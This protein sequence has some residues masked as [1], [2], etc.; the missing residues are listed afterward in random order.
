MLTLRIETDNRW[1]ALALTRK[2]ARYHW[3]LVE[4]DREHETNDFLLTRGQRRR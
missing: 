4:P 1:D 3:F 2:L